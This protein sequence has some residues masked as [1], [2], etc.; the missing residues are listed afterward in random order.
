MKFAPS[1][2]PRVIGIPPGAD[3][4]KTL[5]DNLV[6][7]SRG[8]PPEMLARAQVL[9]S[10]QR[11]KRR[12]LQLFE[13]GEARLLPR[14]G[15]VTD[16]THMIPGAALPA[17]VSSLR[18]ILELKEV[19]SKLVEVDPSLSQTSA[20]DLTESLAQLLDE[21]EGEGVP[22]EKLDAISG[23]GSSGHWEQ[24]LNFLKAIRGY[25]A[26]LTDGE[27]DT[28][29]RHRASV[30]LL[31]QNWE[32]RPPSDP[33]IVAG[34]TGSRDTTHLLMSAVARLP[35]GAVVLPGFDF[36]LLRSVWQGFA[37]SR[38]N[39]DHPQFRFGR[40]L[41]ALA[42]EDDHVERWGQSANEA[43]N[44]L[45]SLSL[46]PANITDQWRIEGPKLG[47]L[48]DATKHLTLL[49]TAQ[50][51]DESL[52]IAIALRHAIQDGKR[53]A[54]IS[55]DATL[56]RRV[57]VAL[58]RWGIRADDSAGTPLHLTPAGRFIRQ[59]FVL[60]SG[61]AKI[62]DVIALLKHPL[63]Q[64]KNRGSF[65]LFVQ[66]LELFLRRA[67]VPTLTPDIVRTFA[68]DKDATTRDFANW[69]IDCLENSLLP[70]PSTLDQIVK[71]HVDLALALCADDLWSGTDGEAV[72]NVI[73]TFQREATVDGEVKFSEY[74]QMLEKVLA[75]ESDRE[76]MGVRPDVSIW[77]TLEARVQGADVVILG[78]L[79][80]GIWPE[81]PS[82]DPWLNR[83]MRAEIGLLLPERQIG[84]AAHDYQQAAGAPEV[85]F[86]RARRSEDS[87]TVPSRWLN[88]LTNLLNG[89]PG[90]HGPEALAAMRARGQKYVT[91]ARQLDMPAKTVPPANRPA[92]APPS[93][94]RPKEYGVTEL[95]R[96]IR[97]PY[98]IYAKR[99]L[100]LEP[101]DPLTPLPDARLK[102][103]VFHDIFER[104]FAIDSNFTDRDASY[105]RLLSIAHSELQNAVHWP[106]TRVHWW[107]QLASIF[108]RLFDD[109]VERRNTTHQLAR[110]VKGFYPVPDTPFRIKGKADRI[111]RN[112]EGLIIY[113]YKTGKPPSKKEIE[114]FDRQLVI[115]A[116]MAEAGAFI[117]VPPEPVTQVVHVGLGRTPE[118]QST[119]LTGINDLVSVLGDLTSFLMKFDDPSTGY[120]ARRAMEAIRYEGDYDHLARFGEWDESQG[121]TPE[122]M[123]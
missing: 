104:F 17:P 64:R 14:I 121:S 94:I 8:H 69:L 65:Q 83:E 70:L 2:T 85:I 102:G 5:H 42:M 52:A 63:T 51:R 88:R 29:A 114:L 22:L 45:I 78:G 66:S 92:P 90:T 60:L 106:A 81:Q 116:L 49:E 9:V 118:T 20:I 108:D 19:V 44:Q 25:L 55:P 38:E 18:R 97:D 76:Q 123:E 28:E 41:H 113:D 100:Q 61:P 50:P 57:S 58:N 30:R 43:R 35:Q 34:S 37:E 24:S 109:E 15:V 4:P 80:E 10:T 68:A 98:A 13:Q 120:I 99:I 48:P 96:L 110:E 1:D 6:R 27:A 72:R 84:L 54:L 21:M 86:S 11:M 89:L 40:F 62:V 26:S 46:R 36:D 79:N 117:D 77:G 47:D 53:A 82:S 87:D 3:F 107:A 93:V 73:T 39:E 33:V 122:P 7:L 31:C 111:D 75:A 115:E 23:T 74:F 56:A 59:V 16:V 91:A 101:L 103:I 71:R 32:L 12:L 95:Q 105:Q 119:E 67:A 112:E